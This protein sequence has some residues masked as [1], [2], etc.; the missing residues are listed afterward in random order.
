MLL[1]EVAKN[2]G[3]PQGLVAKADFYDPKIK[4]K[5]AFQAKYPQVKGVRY[6]LNWDENPKYRMAERGG[7]MTDP[8][9][10]ES[11]ALLEKYNFSFDLHIWPHQ[12]DDAA[13]LIKNFPNI[14]FIVDHTG[15]HKGYLD[16]S[17]EAL[18]QWKL[19]L[20]K[21]ATFSNVNLKISGLSMT[22][23]SVDVQTFFPF[24]TGAIDAFG[25]DRVMFASNFPVDKMQTSYSNLVNTIKEC[26]KSF[27]KNDQKKIFHDNAIRIY[28]L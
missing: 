5:L 2:H 10:R 1:K 23:H 4:E 19:C 16:E 24:V 18:E 25:V 14:Q 11:F 13:D 15:L 20:K 21:L 26:V 9:W 12:V 8:K 27:S 28:R 22:H 6:L 3:Y 7:E 17:N